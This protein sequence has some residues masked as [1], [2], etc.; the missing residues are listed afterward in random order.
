MQQIVNFIS[1]LNTN[2]RRNIHLGLDIFIDQE[3][4]EQQ[5]TVNVRSRLTVAETRHSFV[6][7]HEYIQKSI[8]SIYCKLVSILTASTTSQ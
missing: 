5:H 8:I 6:A 2:E 3:I 4:F 7:Q 1:E